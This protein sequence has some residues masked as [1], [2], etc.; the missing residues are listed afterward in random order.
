MDNK[1]IISNFFSVNRGEKP[2]GKILS[3]FTLMSE[4]KNNGFS[5]SDI[6][7]DFISTI[8]DN[9]ILKKLSPNKKVEA[10][11]WIVEY[12]GYFYK[13]PTTNLPTVVK[14]EKKKEEKKF[15]GDIFDI[16]PNDLPD[17]EY[18]WEFLKALG[19]ENPE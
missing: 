8:Y 9:V 3:L 13:M 1:D 17:M 7:E 10:M 12:V 2:S 18:D 6:N 14:K 16:D 15:S 4:L 5:S 19:V 11:K